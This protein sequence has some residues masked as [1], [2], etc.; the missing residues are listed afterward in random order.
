M[1]PVAKMTFRSEDCGGGL[2]VVAPEAA[3][4]GG[5]WSR[6]DDEERAGGPPGGVAGDVIDAEGEDEKGLFLSGSL[7]SGWAL[8]SASASGVAGLRLALSRSTVAS[9]WSE[10]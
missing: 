7:I 10:V 1:P 8:E 9:I 4:G 2:G 3:G 6:W 5:S